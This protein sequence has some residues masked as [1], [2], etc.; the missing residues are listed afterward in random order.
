M[1]LR[2][3]NTSKGMTNGVR[4]IIT[5]MYNRDAELLTGQSEG[6]QV[7]IPKISLMPSDTDLPF[8]LRRI[9]FSIRFAYA[10]TINKAKTNLRPG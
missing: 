9:Q 4:I 8:H 1:L 2:N 10:M 6:K 7:F 3:I 5:H